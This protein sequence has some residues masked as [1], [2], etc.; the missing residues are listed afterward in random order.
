TRFSRDWSSDVCSSDLFAS[1]ETTEPSTPPGG[2]SGCTSLRYSHQKSR[3]AAAPEAPSFRATRTP[4]ATSCSPEPSPA[5][6]S[7]IRETGRS[8]E[9]RVGEESRDGA[10]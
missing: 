7:S 4:T 9:R 5:K 6:K 10:T 3:E 2:I 1:R 8:E